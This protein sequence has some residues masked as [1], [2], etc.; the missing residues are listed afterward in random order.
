MM[1]LM[2]CVDYESAVAKAW[3]SDPSLTEKYHVR[4]GQGLQV[5]ISDTIDVLVK[6]PALRFYDVYED[7]ELA[8]FFATEYFRYGNFLTT[9]F[10]YPTFRS[11]K[12]KKDFISLILEFFG[13]EKDLY[14]AVY[15]HNKRA[16]DFLESSGFFIIEIGIDKEKE[17]YIFKYE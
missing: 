7:E 2:E 13:T 16:V 5:C 3:A 4:A 11:L 17:F 14:T 10:L 15:S 8:G 6:C 12:N 9:F 1:R